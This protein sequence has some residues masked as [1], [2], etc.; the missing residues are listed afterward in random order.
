MGMKGA[1]ATVVARM[2]QRQRH[3]AHLRE[4]MRW[5]EREKRKQPPQETGAAPD[6]ESG[7][8]RS[9]Q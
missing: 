3:A 2:K 6:R 8:E 1:R 4:G 9:T 7:S 5:S